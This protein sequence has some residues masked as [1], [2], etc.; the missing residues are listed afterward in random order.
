MAKKQNGKKQVAQYAGALIA[1]VSRP[2][3]HRPAVVTVF[4]GCHVEADCPEFQGQDAC[5]LE[6][7]EFVILRPE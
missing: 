1:S 6:S 5:I 3:F 7:G 4:E 2:D